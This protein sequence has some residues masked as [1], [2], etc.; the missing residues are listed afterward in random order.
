MSP[1]LSQIHSPADLKT[2]SQ[3]ELVSLAAEI[4]E[5]IL[6]VVSANGGHLATNLGS[7]ELTLA[8]HRVFDSPQDQI[9]WDVGNQAYAHKLVTG[10]YE[11]FAT[12]RKQGGL[13]GFLRRDESP[14]DQFGAGHAST[15]ISAGTG[16]ACG[17]DLAGGKQQVVVIV[18]DGALTGGLSFEGL[19]NAGALGKNLLVVLNDNSMSISKNVGAIAKFLTTFLT[20][21]HYNKLK[22]D[23]W[24]LTGRSKQGR[25]IRE[26]ISHIDENIKGFFVPGLLFERLG[27]RY[28]GPIDGHDIPQLIRVFTH[29]KTLP[30]PLLLH[31]LTVKGKG[32]VPAEHDPA[33]FHGV[34][35]FDKVTGK[36]NAAGETAYQ[37]VFGE[38][39]VKI[40]EKNRK[41]VA[42]TA[43]MCTGTGLV[44]FAKKFPERFFDVGIAEE[45]GATFAAGLACQ[46]IKPVYAIYSTFLQRAFDQVVHDVALQNIPV[47]FAVDRAGL[48]GDDG[49]THHGV[50]DLSYLRAIPNFTV[51]APKDGNEFKDLLWSAF[52]WQ[53]GPVAIRYPRGGIPDK[54]QDAVR[55]IPYGTWQVEREGEEVVIFAVGAMVY[56]ALEAATRLLV[57]GLSPTVVNAR[58]IKPLD[59]KLLALLL[60]NHKKVI[61]VEDNVLAGGFGS[62]ILEWIEAAGK[63]GFTVKRLGIPDQ[64]ITHGPRK[65]LLNQLGLDADGLVRTVRALVP[66]KVPKQTLRLARTLPEAVPPAPQP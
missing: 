58:F 14:H 40:A 29:L 52:D 10:R 43:A 1:F 64:F 44:E 19:N 23:I 35:A 60:E 8:L 36:A 37:A 55:P 38:T 34:G 53:D 51:A 31:V 61:T 20:D 30:G 24:E 54:L 46:G 50:F 27:F 4:R 13:S 25:K 47:L 39:L 21:E 15:G 28:F 26:I 7:V 33:K 48:V 22:T 11:K 5:K 66:A 41:V 32:Y 49:P 59:E 9:I 45:H 3:K 42:I 6:E 57:D 2:L 16:F 18:G 65:L 63:T 12:I 62:A 56:P 17:R